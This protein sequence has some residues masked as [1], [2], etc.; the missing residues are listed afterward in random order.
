MVNVLDNVVPRISLVD[1]ARVILT[2]E[3]VVKMIQFEPE[4]NTYINFEE[5][6][7]LFQIKLD[8]EQIV[9]KLNPGTSCLVMSVILGSK[10][11][12][13]DSLMYDQLDKTQCSAWDQPG[14]G[15]FLLRVVDAWNV[16]F[17][18]LSCQL[19]DAAEFTENNVQISAALAYAKEHNGLT[20]YMSRGYL[21]K[22]V[23]HDGI[24]TI[25]DH[26]MNTNELITKINN[27][28]NSSTSQ[29]PVTSQLFSQDEHIRELK[30]IDILGNTSIPKPAF[31]KNFIK[32]YPSNCIS[33]E[34]NPTRFKLTQIGKKLLKIHLAMSKMYSK[35]ITLSQFDPLAIELKKQLYHHGFVVKDLKNILDLK[36]FQP[37]PTQYILSADLPIT[38]LN[39]HC[40]SNVVSMKDYKCLQAIN[41]LNENPDLTQDSVSTLLWANE[42]KPQSP[43]FWQRYNSEMNKWIQSQNFT[44]PKWTSTC[45]KLTFSG[46]K[47]LQPILGNLEKCG[48]YCK[49]HFLESLRTLILVLDYVYIV[50]EQQRIPLILQT[51]YLSCNSSTLSTTNVSEIQFFVQDMPWPQV[52][53]LTY[54]ATHENQT[55]PL[56]FKMFGNFESHIIDLSELKPVNQNNLI[57][58]SIFIK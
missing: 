18:I 55:L 31:T 16:A 48:S 26:I 27:W 8:D 22:V 1:G 35:F 33:I 38:H 32:F 53:K 4:I 30:T 43:Q 37:G 11:A 28:W 21:H 52:F 54:C 29:N 14:Y 24:A 23:K 45:E 47:C 2:M 39:L 6:Q 17:G 40:F 49:T 3:E 46:L 34:Q 7:L 36:S 25:Q 12:Y 10:T 44:S 51:A 50:N 56:K 19:F 9:I 57:L 20:F 58:F 41:V 15:G 13:L 42:K 5:K